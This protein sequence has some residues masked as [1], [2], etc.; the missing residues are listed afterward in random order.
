MVL[1]LN[2]YSIYESELLSKQLSL[3]TLT[4]H[5]LVIIVNWKQRLFKLYGELAEDSNGRKDIAVQTD[6]MPETLE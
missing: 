2:L 5:Y 3:N 1:I 4:L 6:I